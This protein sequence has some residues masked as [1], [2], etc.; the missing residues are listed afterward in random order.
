MAQ[1]RFRLILGICDTARLGIDSNGSDLAYH[2]ISDVRQHNRH[3]PATSLHPRVASPYKL[4]HIV[5]QIIYC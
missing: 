1:I 2:S 3:D 4:S 5:K